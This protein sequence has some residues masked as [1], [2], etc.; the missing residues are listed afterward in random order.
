MATLYSQEG[1]GPWK[2]DQRIAL[3]STRPSFSWVI[4]SKTKGGKAPIHM[5]SAFAARMA[6][7]LLQL[8]PEKPAYGSIARLPAG[9]TSSSPAR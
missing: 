4:S 7:N 2:A 9:M 3:R 1:G 6:Q 5:V 8:A